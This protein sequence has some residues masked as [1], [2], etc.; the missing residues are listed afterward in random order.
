MFTYDLRHAS[1][2][3]LKNPGFSIAAI[4]TLALGIGANTAIFSVFNT[5]FL[6]PLGYP[7]PDRIVRFVLTS[8][9]GS[10]PSA[11]VALFNLWRGETDLF[12]DVTGYSGGGS[13]INLT[14]GDEPEQIRGLHVTANYFRLFGA[15]VER[16]RTFTPAEDQPHGP[17]VVVL[18]ERLWRRRYGGDPG[19]VGKTIQLG[20]EPHAVVGIIKTG[21][22]F[23][24]TPDVWI[25]LQLE[26]QGTDHAQFF[27]A[28]ARLKPGVSLDVAKTRLTLTANTF[29]RLYPAQAAMRPQGFSLQT[30]PDAF[31]VDIRSSLLILAGAV[32][33]VL[34]I[35]CA[36]VA[37]LQLVRATGRKREMAIRAALGASR[38]QL[39]RQL[40]A[41]NVVLSLVGGAA[42]LVLGIIGLRVLLT[43]SPADIPRIASLSFDWRVCLFVAFIS[44]GTGILFGLIPALGATGD[45]RQSGV[46]S[47]LVVAEVALAIVLLI[48][49]S[50]LIRSF[51]SLRAVNPGFDTHHVVTMLMAYSG[52]RFERTAGVAQMVSAGIDRISSMP[53][54]VAVGTTCCMPLEGSFNL[55]LTILGKE[56]SD[57]PTI[58]GWTSIAPGYFDVFRIP[59]RRGRRFSSQEPAPV[60]IANTAL[61][62]RFFHNR[63]P[64]GQRILIGKG[65]A[66]EEPARQIIGVVGDVR[67]AGLN[68]DPRPMVYV[69]V[70]QVPDKLTLLNSRSLPLIWVVRT[71]SD[72]S[73]LQSAIKT[74]LLIATGLPAEHLQSMDEVLVRSTAQEAFNT[75]LLVLF[76]ISAVLLAAIGIYGLQAHSVQHRTRELGI[77]MALGADGRALQ[78]AMISQGMRLV[79]AGMLIGIIASLAL[80]RLMVSLIYGVKPWDARVFIAAPLILG[81]VAL[82]A[83]WIPARRVTRIDPIASLRNFQ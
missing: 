27:V 57:V 23:Y 16:G 69:P 52:P 48:G 9:S 53:G 43:F 22:E 26:P 19:I 39:I 68:S 64:I 45:F 17:R 63:D 73:D 5:V 50:L 3:L 76:G 77:R 34:L 70:S 71:R 59:L 55:G 1:R 65:S 18:A 15:P 38:S 36:N 30:M 51:V 81:T 80:T 32:G 72:S 47:I 54:V 40:L 6:T 67:D 74:E 33:F 7:D 10:S 4:A 44:L 20:G 56:P 46:R 49:A 25:P 62:K 58:I 14:G 8:P 42:G 41:E 83:A 75:L 79:A 21:F 13:A 66:F 28:A 37:N 24:P 35:A 31:V 60:V 82:I 29:Q 2:G 78:N 11:S 61:V 12:D